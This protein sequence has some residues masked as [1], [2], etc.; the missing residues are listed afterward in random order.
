MS[1]FW[2][3]APWILVIALAAALIIYIVIQSRKPTSYKELK[4]K[5]DEVDR[6]RKEAEAALI[7][8]KVSRQNAEKERAKHELALLETKHKEKLEELDDKER[9]VYEKAKDDPQSG[10]DYINSLLGD[11]GNGPG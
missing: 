5:F 1:K 9:K 2:I 4:L 11:G 10:V 3:V 7:K 6:K 8:E